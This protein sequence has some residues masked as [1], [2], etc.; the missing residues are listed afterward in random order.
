MENHANVEFVAPDGASAAFSALRNFL[1]ESPEWGILEKESTEYSDAVDGDAIMGAGT[2][3]GRHPGIAIA[4]AS[5]R[6]FGRGMRL[7]NILPERGEIT[8]DEYNRIARDFVQ[9][10]RAFAKRN[11]LA[12]VA[13]MRVSRTPTTLKQIMPGALTRELF[14]RFLLPGGIWGTPPIIHPND[15][16]RLDIFICALH[17]WKSSCHIPALRQWL[18]VQ[19]HWPEKDVTWLC[20]RIEAGLQIL[21]TRMRFH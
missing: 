7:M 17:R 11:A 10:F 6:D 9:C 2:P 12:T 5:T 4:I 14:E 20:D 13:R 16:E 21:Q 19:K 15:I 8:T 3:C 18:K 1:R